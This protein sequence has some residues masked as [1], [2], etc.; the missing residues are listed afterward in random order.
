VV[1]TLYYGAAPS[2]AA[3]LAAVNAVGAQVYNLGQ[4]GAPGGA[5]SD[6]PVTGIMAVDGNSLP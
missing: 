2:E 1:F 5:A 6:S 3:A 4:S